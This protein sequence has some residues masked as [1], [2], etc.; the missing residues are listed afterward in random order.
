[1]SGQIVQKL[2]NSL[3]DIESKHLMAK[4]NFEK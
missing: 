3:S 2:L 4:E 1:M